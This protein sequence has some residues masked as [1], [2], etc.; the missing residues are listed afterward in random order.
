MSRLTLATRL[1]ALLLAA[2]TSRRLA[3]QS[4]PAGALV[5]AGIHAPSAVRSPSGRPGPGY[6]QQRADYVID[7]TLDPTAS[8]VTGR[9]TI[10][11]QN[12]SPDALPELWLHVEQNIC[13][14]TSVASVLDQPPLVFLSSAFDFSCK[15]FVGG[16]SLTSVTVDGA[17]ARYTVIGTTMRIDLSRPLAPGA[18]LSL[19]IGWRFTVPPYGAGRMGHDG[20]LYE[21]GQWYPRMAVYDDVTGWNHEP[22]IGAGEFY[23][24]YGKFEV[25]LTLPGNYLVAATGVLQNAAE[26]L[27]QTQRDRLALARTSDTAI[28]IVTKAEAERAPAHRPTGP[29][30]VRTWR[31]VADSVRDFA[32]A[33]APNFRWDAS[34]YDGIQINTYY[35]PTATLWPEANR[36]AREAVKHYSEQWLRYPYPH[37]SSIEGPIEGMEYP[38]MTFDPTGPVRTDLQWVVAHELGHQWTPMIVGSNERLYPW[39]DEGFNTFIDLQNAANYFRGTPYGDTIEVHPLHLYNEHALTGTEQPLITRPVEVRDLFWTGYQKPALMMRTLREHV[40][41]RERFDDAF[42]AYLAAW[43]FKHPTPGDFFRMMRS[44]TG[45]D[46]DW[47]WR[48]WVYTT[49][50]PDQAVEA[51]VNGDSGARV[52]LVNKGEM[53]LPVFLRVTYADRST[54][55]VTLPVD[56]W[57]QGPR[58]TWRARNGKR[59]VKAEVDPQGLFPDADRSNNSWSAR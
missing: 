40:L 47:Y 29:L 35:R 2:S 37:A 3:A 31:F 26:V 48:D 5:G 13:S 14:P 24:E 15:G 10:R 34:N 43:A 17:P 39:M 1:F 19:G 27:S 42:R 18:T 58:F 54:E 38:M 49:N 11:Y 4:T 12:N 23:L 30:A 25:N 22:Y 55:S 41:G 7:V 50:R 6:W 20:T 53:Q 56:L 52:V 46:L 33:A 44:R 9:E 57:N 16:D 21:L 36:M 32:I 45:V 51:V 8:L 59:V 28:Q